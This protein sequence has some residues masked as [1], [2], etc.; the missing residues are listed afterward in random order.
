MATI[1]ND[2]NTSKGAMVL[3]EPLSAMCSRTVTDVK[4]IKAK[5]A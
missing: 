4:N 2:L 3:F 5:T 1:K